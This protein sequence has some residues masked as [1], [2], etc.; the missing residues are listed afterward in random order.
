MHSIKINTYLDT[1]H[2]E[3]ESLQ[4]F[5]FLQRHYNIFPEKY[6]NNLG[7]YYMYSVQS[8]LDNNNNIT[9]SRFILNYEHNLH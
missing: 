3:T 9:I 6:I 1:S 8:T 7:Y 5:I 2:I 4:F